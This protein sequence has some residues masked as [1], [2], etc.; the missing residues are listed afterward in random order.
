[1][2]SLAMIAYFFPPEGCAGVYRPL[3]FLRELTKR[4]WSTT[5]I[6]ADPYRYERYD[7]ELLA[8]VPR[9]ARIIRVRGHDP[10]QA[11]QAWRAKTVEKLSS[12]S[13]EISQQIVASHHAPLRSRLR[14]S[15]QMIERWCYRPDM[16]M[17]WIQ[18]ALKKTVGM[19]KADRPDVIWATIGPVSSGVVANRASLCTGVPYILDFRD[20][21]GL[22]YYE[23]EIRRPS[24]AKFMDRRMMHRMLKDAQTAIFLSHS[25]ADRYVHVFD[26]ALE[27]RKIHI[28]PNGFDG[29][30]E[31]FKHAPGDICR[32][33]YTGTLASYRYDTLLHALSMLNTADSQLAGRFEVLFVGEGLEDLNAQAT[34]LGI[35]HMVKICPP[36]SYGE[37]ER[38]QEQAHALLVLGRNPE[39]KG[40]ELLVGAKLFAYFK[41]GR[42][43][44]AVVPQDETRKIL[45]RVGV[46]TVA[47][48]NSVSAIMVVLRDIFSKWSTGK[49]ASLVPDRKACQTYSSGQQTEALERAL[50]GLPPKER[51][52]S[53]RLDLSPRVPGDDRANACLN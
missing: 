46:T 43:I 17:P 20:P 18:P 26:G 53:G 16:A 27:D 50:Q 29:D 34:K 1:M 32:I 45:Q 47:D 49:L 10:W 19:W 9:E 14:E 28:I 41:A 38:L 11:F 23:S 44:V 33:L 5:V 8:R 13:P 36:T 22:D 7:A 37:I 40:H 4:G 35:S 51:F 25:V 52:V 31:E 3:R 30:I 39:R 12:T 15:V 21:W 6:C 42:P 2:K 24:W 48:A